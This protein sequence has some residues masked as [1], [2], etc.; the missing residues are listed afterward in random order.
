MSDRWVARPQIAAAG[1]AVDD[2]R[3]E[4]DFDRDQALARPRRVDPMM[5]GQSLPSM[6]RQVGGIVNGVRASAIDGGKVAYLFVGLLA[7]L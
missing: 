1:L 4:G 2:Q 5:G 6:T 7:P 3:T